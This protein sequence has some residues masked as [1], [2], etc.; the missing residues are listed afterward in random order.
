M[1]GV[2]DHRLAI[3][4]PVVI[5]DRGAQR[6][7]LELTGKR[8]H[9]RRATACCTACPGMKV[10]RHERTVAHRLVQMAMAVDA[11]R[12]YPTAG[13]VDVLHAL[14][15]T[16]RERRDSAVSDTNVAFEHVG[17]CCHSRIADN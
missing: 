4:A 5:V 17:G 11:T 3:R 8:N 6:L 14:A 7:P 13:S 16:T 2:V 9:G 12:K 10:V 15:K 1:E